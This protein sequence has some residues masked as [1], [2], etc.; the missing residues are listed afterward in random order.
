MGEAMIVEP[1]VIREDVVRLSKELYNG[2]EVVAGSF[3][4]IREVERLK[5]VIE[6]YVEGRVR[7]VD[8][9][10]LSWRLK[11]L[12]LDPNPEVLAVAP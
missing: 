3:D 8:V 2:V 5:G 1:S 11:G 6:S 4:E 10:L 7:V 9:P 12:T